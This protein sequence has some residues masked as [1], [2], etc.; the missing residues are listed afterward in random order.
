MSDPQAYVKK[1]ETDDRPTKDFK[2]QGNVKG[3]KAFLQ[4]QCLMNQEQCL[5]NQEQPSTSTGSAVLRKRLLDE[6]EE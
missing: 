2:S 3:L 4:E 6:L 1:L 5:M